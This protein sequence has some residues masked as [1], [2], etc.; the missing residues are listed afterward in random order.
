MISNILSSLTA[1]ELCAAID[2]DIRTLALVI[3]YGARIALHQ[4]AIVNI[5]KACFLAPVAEESRKISSA[6]ATSLSDLLLRAGAMN[7]SQV[8]VNS[9]VE[10]HHFLVLFWA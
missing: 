8:M 5:Q 1:I 2:K 9:F 7:P 6:I 4:T 3:T 10:C